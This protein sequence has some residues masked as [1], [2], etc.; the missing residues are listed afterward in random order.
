M[1]KIYSF[2]LTLTALLC[3]GTGTAWGDE[4]TVANDDWQKEYLPIYGYNCDA[5][6]GQHNQYI[7]PAS[8]LSAMNGKDI[9]AMTFYTVADSY[10]FSS[11]NPPTVTIKFAEVDAT[12]LSGL[13]SETFSQ[14]YSGT[15]TIA[16]GMWEVEFDDSYTYNGG[17]LLVDVTTTKA[18]YVTIKWY[19]AEYSNAGYYSYGYSAASTSYLPKTTFTYEV[20][21]SCAKPTSISVPN[22]F[23][24][25]TSAKITWEGE[26]NTVLEYKLHS[27]EDWTVVDA[28]DAITHHTLTGLAPNKTKYDVRVKNVCSE[29][30]GYISTSFETACGAISNSSLPWNFGFEAS[31]G[32]TT[33]SGN[34]PT[35][36][37]AV[38]YTS[39]GTVFPYVYGYYANSGSN[40]LYF[41]GGASGYESY[42]ILPEFEADLED[43]T[44]S[45]YYKTYSTS[46][47]YPQFTVGYYDPENPSTFVALE[48]PLTRT[49]SYTFHEID[50]KDVPTA[51]K[52]IVIRWKGS[53]SYYGYLDDLRII[54]T[55]S[56]AKPSGLEYSAPTTH[57]VTLSWTNGGSE[58]EWIIEYST[59]STFASDVH[60]VVTDANPFTI[61]T[62]MNANTVYYAR[63]KASC[64]EGE[65]NKSDW[66]NNVV[67]FRTECDVVAN[68]ELPW[69]YGFESGIP[70]GDYK[71]PY[72]WQRNPDDDNIWVQTSTKRTGSKA[73]R[74]YGGGSSSVRT[75]IFPGFEKNIANLTLEFYY[76]TSVYD[77]YYGTP[78][79]GYV[80]TSGTFVALKTLDQTSSFT[81]AEFIY[82]SSYEDTPAN[83]AIQYSGG[84]S[85]YG[86]LYI[87]DVTVKETPACAKPSGL[88]KSAQTNNSATL[89][90]TKNGSET[91]WNVQYSTT[92][93][94]SSDNHVA[95][96]NTN[97]SYVLS[98]LS[99][100]THYY[101]HVQAA[102]EGDYSDA[103]DFTTDCDAISS[104]STWTDGGFEDET[105]NDV[106]SCWIA[107]TS[108][109]SNSYKPAMYVN[110]SATY[111]RTG[112]KSLLMKA[113]N[114]S[115]EGYAIFPVISDASL[116]SLQ[117]KFWHKKEV[118][119]FILKVGYLT[120]INDLSSFVELHTSTNATDW[121]EET[122]DLS[123]LPA[124]ARLA[125]YYFGTSGTSKYYVAV[126]DITF[127][128]P[129]T[130]FKPATLS[131]ASSIT[132]DGATFSWEA[133]GHGESTYQ[134]AVAAGSDAPVWVDDAT[135]KTS[136]LSKAVS[137]LAAGTYKFYVRSYCDSEDQSDAAVSA[138]FT[139]ATVT[140]P[141]IGTITTTNETAHATWTAPDVT[142]SV[143]YQW[144]TDGSSWSAATSNLYADISDLDANTSYTFYVRS[145]YNASHVGSVVTKTFKTACDPSTVTVGTPF[146]QNFNELS[147]AGQ[148]PDCWN[149]DEVTLPNPYASTPTAAR[150]WSYY[151]T[152]YSGKCVR[153]DSYNVS[154]G[155][156]NV[157]TSPIIILNTD[158]DLSFYAKNPKGGDYKVQISVNGG[159]RADLVTGLTN[160]SSWTKKEAPLTYSAGTKIQLFFVGTSNAAGGDAYLYLDEV[161]ITPVTCRKPASDPV[162]DSKDD[163]HATL[164][165]T[166][167]GANTDYQF[168]LALKDEAPV[169]EAANVVTG[170]SKSFEGLA[171]HSWYDFYVRTYCDE[172]NQSDYRKVSF[173]TDCGVFALPFEE[174]FNG[175]ADVT[176]P[177]CWDN[178][179]GSIT[180][181]YKKWRSNNSNYLRFNSSTTD[182]DETSILATPTIQLGEGNLLSFKAMNPTGGAFKVQIK[183][184][185][186]AAADLLTGLTDIADWTLKYAAIPA[187]YNNK[188]VQFLFH[189][190]SNGGDG[191]AYIYIDDVRVT[192][193]EI[194]NDNENNASRFATL[195]AA[196]ETMDVIFNRT[197]LCNG[198]Y[199]TLCLPFSLDADQLAESPLA[200]FKLKA[201]DY[202]SIVGDELQLA[203]APASSIEAGIP[204]FAAYQGSIANQT[205][206]L[207]QDVVI[208]ANTPGSKEDGDIAYQ[209]VF[210]PV[211]LAAQSEGGDHNELFLAS[212]NTIYW[213]AQAK[214]VKGFRAYFRVT[215]GGSALRVQKGM[216]ARLV[217]RPNAPTGMDNVQ[218][219]EVQS[220]KVL[221]N[222]QVVIIRNGVKY[223][224]Q[225]QIIQ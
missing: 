3:L 191:N 27:A 115:G 21:S 178:S 69:S 172:L 56:C 169:W 42:I 26:N 206:Q 179:E 193:G 74:L 134:W 217:E 160:L 163:T 84:T 70:S 63:V 119:A 64:G 209:G 120:N 166:A 212:G 66:C 12:T 102:C 158:A 58:S 54:R 196:G 139:T 174:N 159:E 162:V 10:T 114:D 82:P 124:G 96:A 215:V 93:D 33:G 194:F 48:D 185:G 104:A 207:Y 224:V 145:Y 109:E 121:T 68:A 197:V 147:S 95:V 31:D 60:E 142:Y 131:A 137:G 52:N 219:N 43:L 6:G 125:F 49:T 22:E 76:Q 8:E 101:V 81:K 167:G 213:P 146:V 164:T 100:N 184:E 155:V 86:S 150:K 44:L 195:K 183:E 45:F 122:V 7:F 78:K 38:T 200:N 188:K 11:N 186:Q 154:N 37:D 112:S 2:L 105:V 110:T 126:D 103:I 15:V 79:I 220:T 28:L 24:G 128:A 222:N 153:Y 83:I 140:A 51:A 203:I 123:T 1:K 218:D 176:T 41:N 141:T 13:R 211:D 4:L 99:A 85:D 198:D 53:Y 9:T 50:L 30:S 91:S 130:C 46:S 225:G 157:F 98:G 90:W 108:D 208:T 57:G 73:L 175:L 92:S 5:T 181:E 32:C 111:V 116:S 152:G 148:I 113:Y 204:Y 88:S 133:S 16:S 221:E 65:E 17:N 97:N 135:H 118:A 89:S 107:K 129:P 40:C 67:D 19:S 62:G 205:V 156:V 61:S 75:I 127:A 25:S 20:A 136:E 187:A 192:R 39:S 18:G 171:S 94:F 34:I 216:R 138:S 72:C 201:F 151:A 80:N 190:T 106:P 170:L 182:A 55:P 149:N 161:E 36:W 199:N 143:Q 165:W 189:A 59:S 23:L 87:D 168:A 202:A 210:N 132:P 144:S 223:S 180:D 47:S 214:V 77:S 117:L 35:C 173:Q 14:V 71:I 29:P 177:E